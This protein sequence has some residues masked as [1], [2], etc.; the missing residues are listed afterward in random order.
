MVQKR[1]E[2]ADHL[3]KSQKHSSRRGFLLAG[4]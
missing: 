3:A 2:K 4:I 1:Y